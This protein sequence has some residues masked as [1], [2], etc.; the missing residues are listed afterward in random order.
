MKIVFDMNKSPFTS[1]LKVLAIVYLVF[2][3]IAGVLFLIQA[4]ISYGLYALE[5]GIIGFCLI[6]GLAVIIEELR[7]IERSV[8][9]LYTPPTPE[10]TQKSDEFEGW[11]K[12]NPGKTIGDFRRTN[13]QPSPPASL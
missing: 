1:F 7:K 6:W 2:L 9:S 10:R 3:I 4:E 12:N 8:R 11:L 5:A 13:R